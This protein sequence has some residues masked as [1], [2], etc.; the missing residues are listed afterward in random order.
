MSAAV[1]IIITPPP[2]K[3]AAEVADQIAAAVRSALD[4]AEYPDEEPVAAGGTD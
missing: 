1:I 2:K 3:T 4:A